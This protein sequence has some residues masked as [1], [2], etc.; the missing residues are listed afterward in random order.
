MRKNIVLQPLNMGMLNQWRKERDK[1]VKTYDVE[2]FKK[3][4]IKWTKRGLYD[5]KLPADEVIEI[6][7]RK[8]FIT[9]RAQHR[10]RRQKRK[11]G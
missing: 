7:M 5:M 3:F 2:A 6:S 4:Y 9:W 10:N 11:H 8:W 1:V